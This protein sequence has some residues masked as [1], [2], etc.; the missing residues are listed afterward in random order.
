ME[1]WDIYD[2]KKQLTGRTMVRNDWHMKPGDYHLT[3]LALLKTPDGRILITQRQGN[4]EWAAG[5]WEIP[6]GGVRSG[7]TSVQAVLR[8][9]R[10]ETGLS[11][12]AGE[13]VLVHTYRNDSPEEQ[14]N[15]FVDI[16]EIVLPFTAED[17]HV[18]KEEVSDFMIALPEQVRKMG[19]AGN[20]LHYS[21]F[22]AFL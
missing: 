10:E 7:E 11:A 3:V 17:V 2:Q 19:E 5:K 18:Q 16:Y 21:H 14:N 15:Y 22:A 4:K 20:I 13:A 12:G 1:Y 6:G 8:E 9:V